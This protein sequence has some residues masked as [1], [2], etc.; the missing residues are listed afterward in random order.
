MT[1]IIEEKDWPEMAQT[2]QKFLACPCQYFAPMRD[3]EPIW[4]AYQAARERGR[5]E[6]FTPVLL[7]L[8]ENLLESCL[9]N[10]LPDYNDYPNFDLAAVT[11][12]RQKILA[13][14]LPEG[15]E[16]LQEMQADWQE[17]AEEDGWDWEEAIGGDLTGG[18]DNDRF[19][20]YWNYHTRDTQPMLL[21]EIPTANPWEVFAWVPFGG[22]NDCPD[23]EQHM[24]AAKRW[25]ELYDAA[26]AVITMDT[27]EYILPKP[28][29]ETA[30]A[31]RPLA[32]ELYC[33]APDSVDQAAEGFTVGSLA[34][35]LSLST[36][37]YF[38]WD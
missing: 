37:W 28:A 23:T 10:T 26:P 6:G 38:W 1:N 30:E 11:A 25:F 20:G 13:A 29:A 24:T 8:E 5:K 9:Y 7:T 34:E 12:A 21:A 14:P 22:W 3:D 35:T 2:L 33:F 32:V 19:I 36:V 31:A 16:V 15:T 18:E 27:L 17:C 4:Q